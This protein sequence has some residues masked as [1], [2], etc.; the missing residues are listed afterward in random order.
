MKII[1]TLGTLVLMVVCAIVCG[2]G[3]FAMAGVFLMFL[4]LSLHNNYEYYGRFPGTLLLYGSG[5]IGFLAPVVY[6]GPAVIGNLLGR[7][8]PWQFSLRTLLSPRRWLRS[9]WARS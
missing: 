7:K 4:G 9:R 8:R 2:I 6:L 1:E 3:G 5:G